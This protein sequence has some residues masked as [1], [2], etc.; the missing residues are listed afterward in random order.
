MKKPKI[1]FKLEA[2][3]TDVAKRTKEELIMVEINARFVTVVDR[4]KSYKTLKHSLKA[5]I[6]PKN[7]GLAT[8]NFKFDEDVFAKYC[9]SSSG[10]KDLMDNFK[11]HVD[12]LH[13]NFTLNNLHP[14][15]EEF[16]EALKSRTE[17]TS[18][19]ETFGISTYIA[20]QIKYYKGIMNSS[21]GDSIKKRSIQNLETLKAVI[22]NFNIYTK[23]ILTFD[24]LDGEKYWE[25]WRVTD[26]LV[27][28]DI[29]LPIK[30]G[31]RKKATSKNG[32]LSNTIR[33]YQFSLRRILK[34]A[35]E[36]NIK[37]TSVLLLKKY[38]TNEKPSGN[39]FCLTE[40]IL[41]KLLKHTP[42]TERLKKAKDYILFSS[43]TGM[44]FQSVTSSDSIK[45]ESYQN[46]G[47]DFKYLHT[48]QEKTKTECYTPLFGLVVELL[49]TTDGIVP[50]F[51]KHTSTINKQLKALFAEAG[52]NDSIKIVHYTY[53][54][55][56]V[57]ENKETNAIV[58]SHDA[59]RTFTTILYQMGMPITISELVT[60]PRKGSG[61]S[62]KIY[63]KSTN[64]ARAVMFVD[65][66]N[67]LE[68]T[69]NIYCF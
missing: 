1:T 27:K 4:V 58:S 52:I 38:L 23:S 35:Q 51:S 43:L 55:G 50:D 7:F 3:S 2:K 13:S 69:S 19:N 37:I 9:K 65:E 21:R 5:T 64:E 60:H 63:N 24:N 48:V 8:N 29:V 59:R 62:G 10:I 16:Y 45:M 66:F 54:L 12:V 11:G 68:K 26:S 40:D 30:E 22:D 6:L 49:K 25:L 20:E 32:I 36:E 42:S 39:D 56:D 57:V 28:G 46:K 53:S 41:E 14:T 15:R 31:Q 47:Y 18:N 44:R 34:A 67:K 33:S 17:D 61:G